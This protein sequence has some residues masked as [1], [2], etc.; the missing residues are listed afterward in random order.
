M[1]TARGFK[2][3]TSYAARAN[4]E[5]WHSAKYRLYRDFLRNPPS[6]R[7]LNSQK[8]SLNSVQHEIVKD[9]SEQ[10]I[11][12]SSFDKLFGER[13]RWEQLKK[14]VDSFSQGEKVWNGIRDYQAHFQNAG[15]A[16]E[17]V[18]KQY[19]R[20]V[21]V[22]QHDVWLQLGLDLR[23]LDTVNSYLGLWAK[24]IHFDLWYTIPLAA[25]RP[26]IASQQ[27]HRDPEDEK[28]VKVF[29]YF[30]EVD[31]GSGPFQYVPG[32]F[33]GGP[34]AHVWPKTSILDAT[35]PPAEEFES[36]L[37][38]S[39]WISCDGAPGTLVFCDTNGF[40]RGGFATNQAR[41]LATWTFVTPASLFS[42]R[43][44][45]DSDVNQSALPAAARFAIT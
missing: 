34:Y 38:P 1:T 20:Y 32:S 24:L 44:N 39:N 8:P 25:D 6:R 18:I 11:A 19:P 40:H 21:T 31:E 28:L 2:R 33:P 14:A 16:K 17:Y 4:P 9:L 41:I 27:W 30:S 10:G 7:K 26:A 36:V 5:L 29:L 23:L 42:R 45:I 12:T 3:V 13:E 43:F 37:P 35:Y 15:R 22:D